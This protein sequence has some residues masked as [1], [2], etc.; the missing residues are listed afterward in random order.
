MPYLDPNPAP[1]AYNL[2]PLLAGAAQ[3]LAERAGLEGEPEP[4]LLAARRA[5]AG[6]YAG[7]SFAYHALDA[8]GTRS[9]CKIEVIGLAPSPLLL[10]DPETGRDLRVPATAVLPPRQ[11]CR[12]GACRTAFARAAPLAS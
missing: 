10:T 8:S 1:P 5:P 7:V 6:P 3:A 11:R 12:R 9:L 2:D 4:P